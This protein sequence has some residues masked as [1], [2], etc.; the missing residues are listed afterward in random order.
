MKI[1]TKDVV[2]V[3][4]ALAEANKWCSARTVG[5]DRINKL[6]EKALEYL[7]D[8][9]PKK[10]HVGACVDYQEQIHCNSYSNS[11]SST[12]VS[13]T[14]GTRDCFLTYCSRDSIWPGR[15]ARDE[16]LLTLPRKAVEY[17]QNQIKSEIVL[18]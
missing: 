3:N 17:L 10:Y 4:R 9:L 12:R 16:I 8:N 1:N 5:I 15:S 18:D 11:A 6:V 13:I 2:K 7:S 14:V